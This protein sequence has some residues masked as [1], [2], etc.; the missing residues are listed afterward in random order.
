MARSFVPDEPLFTVHLCIPDDQPQPDFWCTPRVLPQGAPI[1]RVGELIYLNSTSAWMVST[2]IHEWLAGGRLR[3][4][5]WIEHVG[6]ARERR[7][8]SSGAVH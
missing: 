8:C 4:E 6:C 5:V 7:P 3:V 2:V 1:P